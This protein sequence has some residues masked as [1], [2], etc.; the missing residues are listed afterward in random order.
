MAVKR[1]LRPGLR[2]Q[3]NQLRVEA[4]ENQGVFMMKGPTWL[5]NPKT[6][7]DD[8][9][10]DFID[11]EPGAMRDYASVPT[12]ANTPFFPDA[13]LLDRKA[14]SRGR[15]C[16]IDDLLQINPNFKPNIGFKYFFAGDLS[17]SGDSTGIS[18]VHYDFYIDKVELDFSKLI[19][20]P[21]GERVDYAPI[22][23]M[24]YRLKKRGFNIVF[25]AFD[26]FQSNDCINKFR[27]KGFE[28]DQVNYAESF[29]GC[30]QLSDLIS[31]DRFVYDDF[32]ESFI[33]EAKE[34]QIVNARRID[35]LK[36]DGLYN[37][38]DTWDSVVNATYVCLMD[39]YNGGNQAQENKKVLGVANKMIAKQGGKEIDPYST[40]WLLSDYNDRDPL[41]LR[42]PFE[43]R[44]L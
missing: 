29:V 5:I 41:D 7:L 19:Y 27:E 31:T 25:C 26:Q 10:P 33:G 44:K 40:D 21:K 3:L 9:I 38:K 35:H 22:R 34:L 8:F 39:H 12:H 1:E 24:V 37:G 6:K 36:T 15:E 17:V 23:A 14:L 43:S 13:T 32:N 20:A 28:S 30:T 16:P 18:L 42:N 11:D 4:Y 2:D